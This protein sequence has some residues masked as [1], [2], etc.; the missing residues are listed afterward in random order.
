MA[1]QFTRLFRAPFSVPNGLHATADG[2]WVADQITD[3]VAFVTRD[4]P[5]DYGVTQYQRELTTESSNTSGLSWGD[6]SLWLAANGNSALW[7]PARA[8]DAAKGRGDILRIDPNSGATL[9]RWPVPDGGGVHGIDYDPIE[10]GILWV[11]TLHS[12]TLS[13]VQ[14]GWWKVERTI[15]LPL[16]RAHGVI[17]VEDGIWVVFTGHRTII[18]LD[19][20]GREMTRINVPADQPEPHCLTRWEN[21]FLYC[22][23]TTGWV[24]QIDPDTL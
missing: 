8:T 16:P 14:V 3:R 22:D 15:P 18:K 13:K 2:L 4:T 24:V 5:N 21:S 6:G 11:T 17:R 1:T 23:A 20:Q 7:R 12:Q 10:P 19:M 9:N